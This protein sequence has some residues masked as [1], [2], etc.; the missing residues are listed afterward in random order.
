MTELARRSFLL[1]AG[2]LAFGASTSRPALAP[3][4]VVIAGGGFAGATCAK[5]LRTYAPGLP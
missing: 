4:R 1:G 2:A 5:Y 3:S